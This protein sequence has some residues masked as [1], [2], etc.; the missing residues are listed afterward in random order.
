MFKMNLHAYTYIYVLSIILQINYHQLD[1]NA[2]VTV[3]FNVLETDM[4]AV[5][6]EH[7]SSDSVSTLM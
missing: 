3:F 6:Y 1:H 5:T 2:Q 4:Q 7:L